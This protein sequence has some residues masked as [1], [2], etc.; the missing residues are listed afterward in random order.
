MTE[1]MMGHEYVSRK[2]CLS[3]GREYQRRP[4]VRERARERRQR[5]EAK[6]RERERER[7]RSQRPE[8]RERRRER[9]RLNQCLELIILAQYRGDDVPR[10]RADLTPGLSGPCRGKYQVDH[11]NGNSIQESRSRRQHG[12]MDG[13]R[14]LDDLRVLC[15]LHQAEYAIVRGDSSGGSSPEDWE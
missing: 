12:V 13:T 1:A 11:I 2:H 10:C 5:P 9:M 8:V 15:E 14:A 6:E 4:E 3:C 7:K